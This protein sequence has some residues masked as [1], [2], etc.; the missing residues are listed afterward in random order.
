MGGGATDDWR[1]AGRR[2]AKGD[3]GYIAGMLDQSALVGLCVVPYA[4]LVAY[5]ADGFLSRALG[6]QS[7]LA[8]SS[9]ATPARMASK[10]FDDKRA[11]VEDISR[12]LG[13]LAAE[14]E[15]AF[16][17]GPRRAIARMLGIFNPDLSVLTLDGRPLLYGAVVPF[18]LGIPSL[19]PDGMTSL[20]PQVRAL[21]ERIGRLAAQLS[22]KLG[23]HQRASDVLD[24]LSALDAVSADYN[25]AAFGGHA[26][27]HDVLLLS[28]LHNNVAVGA[29]LAKAGCCTS[30]TS[31]AVKH[32]FVTTYQA[33]RS[34]Q[35]ILGDDLLTG[36]LRGRLGEIAN[37]DEVQYVLQHR[38]LRNSLVH[39]GLSD[40]PDEIVAASDPTAALIE[41]DLGVPFA[42]AARRIQQAA[43]AL[44]DQL[45]DWL[46]EDRQAVLGTLREPEE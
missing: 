3:L 21:A 34:V 32:Q 43:S 23:Q 46:L 41:A 44:D 37:S 15:E 40:R 35:L 29:Q 11:S 13:N 39:L 6:H 45:V 25:A 26:S 36:I 1:E 27:V 28:L 12:T 20:R 19:G 18:Q 17:G 5:E 2:M 22:I 7:V 10:I 42:E 24:S 4:A 38:A 16:R 14:F 30:C 8:G 9:T 33:A 31:A